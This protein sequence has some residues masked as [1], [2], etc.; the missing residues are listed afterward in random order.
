[1][2]PAAAARIALERTHSNG[3]EFVLH[4][5]V[6][7]ISDFQA[8]NYPG[9]GGLTLDEVREALEVFAQ[10]E[11]SVRDRSHRLQSGEGSRRQRR[12]D[13]HRF[14]CRHTRKAAGGVQSCCTRCLSRRRSRRKANTDRACDTF[15]RAGE[16]ARSRDFYGEPGSGTCC[17]AGRSVVIRF[18]GRRICRS[19]KNCPKPPENPASLL[20]ENSLRGEISLDH[21]LRCRRRPGG[22]A[23]LIPKDDARDRSIFHGQAC[24]VR[25][26]SSLEKSFPGTTTTG[27]FQRRGCVR[28][29]ATSNTK[30]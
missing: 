3:H 21:H 14:A 23:R 19:R 26:T 28:S 16:R 6:D 25:R 11:E 1:M 15:G 5:D 12:Q 27:S 18:A 4:F 8:T 2:G 17:G 22:C 20:L 24:H 29:A 13:R 7:A 30:R 10:A 9:S